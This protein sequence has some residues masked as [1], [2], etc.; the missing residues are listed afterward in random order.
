[1]IYQ[2][3]AK[4]FL[5]CSEQANYHGPAKPGAMHVVWKR[6][7]SWRRIFYTT[8]PQGCGKLHRPTL[9]S[10]QHGTLDLGVTNNLQMRLEQHLV[11]LQRRPTTT[12]NLRQAGSRAARSLHDYGRTAMQIDAARMGFDPDITGV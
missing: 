3:L 12:F 9:A 5:I 4:L 8:V 10:G 11:P 2:R 7:D 1:M 6:K